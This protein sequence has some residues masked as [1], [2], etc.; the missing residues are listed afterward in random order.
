MPIHRDERRNICSRRF[1]RP[2]ARQAT[3]AT[4][5][6]R[7]LEWRKAGSG[8]EGGPISEKELVGWAEKYCAS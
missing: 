8:G 3:D 6:A 7:A 1:C 4:K 2:P 5:R